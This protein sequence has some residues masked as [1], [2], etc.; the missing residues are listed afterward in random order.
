M[1]E[2]RQLNRPF[3]IMGLGG[4][5]NAGDVSMMSVSYLVQKLQARKLAELD[6]EYFYDM[7]VRR[8]FVDIEEGLLMN[9]APPRS[10]YY[11]VVREGKDND[12]LFLL[13][14]EPQLNWESYVNETIGLAQRSNAMMIFILGGLID[15]VLHTASPMITGVVNMPRLKQD[16]IGRGVSLSNY[17]GPS[18]IHSLVLHEAKKREIPAISLWGHVPAYLAG[19]NPKVSHALLT[20]LVEMTGIE[21]DLEEIKKSSDALDLS[22]KDLTKGELGFNEFMRLEKDRSEPEREGP[23]Y[24]A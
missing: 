2:E 21:V 8:P 11:F 1:L 5:A 4:W 22:L 10:D 18:S 6:G 16:L 12:I 3:M 24:L 17:K 9:Y 14:H 19:P 20:K 7:T 15:Q 23:E 13:G